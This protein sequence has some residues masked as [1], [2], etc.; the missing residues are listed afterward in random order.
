MIRKIVF[1]ALFAIFLSNCV[2]KKLN[3]VPYLLALK[4]LASASSVTSQI[5]FGQRYKLFNNH[6]VSLIGY[7]NKA[8]SVYYI[9]PEFNDPDLE[10]DFIKTTETIFLYANYN[11]K[12]LLQLDKCKANQNLIEIHGTFHVKK[13]SSNEIEKLYMTDIVKIYDF[14]TRSKSQGGTGEKILCYSIQ[15]Y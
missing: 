15:Q 1:I 4:N 13:D 3:T 5:I 8:Q 9:N 10:D 14:D 11:T 2:A 7:I 6:Q 12:E